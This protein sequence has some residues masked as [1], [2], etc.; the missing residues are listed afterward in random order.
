MTDAMQVLF[1]YAQEQMVRPFM[2]QDPEY[3]STRFYVEK[4]EKAF[5]ALLNDEMEKLFDD[6]QSERNQLD[7]I[8]EQALFR[9]GFRLA[10]EL[11]R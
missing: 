9:S 1:Q 2:E 5:R 10:L 8:Y 3:S 6:L 7:F 4:R 11:L